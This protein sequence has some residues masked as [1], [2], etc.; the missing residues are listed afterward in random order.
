M[1]TYSL[2]TGSLLA[3]S[4]PPKSPT[5]TR[6]VR[7]APSTRTATSTETERV[8]GALYRLAREA[9]PATLQRLALV[10]GLPDTRE[11]VVPLARL[12]KDNLVQRRGD[13][14]TLSLM[15]FAAAAALSVPRKNRRA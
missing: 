3:L 6:N 5:R 10:I 8:L 1:T 9:E 4:F 2:C 12:A 7:R 11:L 13:T 14:L 15:G